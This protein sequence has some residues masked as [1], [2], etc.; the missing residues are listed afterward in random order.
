MYRL[1]L[2]RVSLKCENTTRI[3]EKSFLGLDLAGVDGYPY[4][5]MWRFEGFPRQRVNKQHGF[6]LSG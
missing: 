1:L 5:K 3:V 4:S 2:W 6:A